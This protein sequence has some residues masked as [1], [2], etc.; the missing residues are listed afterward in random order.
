MSNF[1]FGNSEQIQ[2]IRKLLPSPNLL[3]IIKYKAIHQDNKS[4]LSIMKP[5]KK[6]RPSYHHAFTTINLVTKGVINK[7]DL[8]KPNL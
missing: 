6:L 8:I 2:I 1:S 3:S 5:Q 4:P 7:E